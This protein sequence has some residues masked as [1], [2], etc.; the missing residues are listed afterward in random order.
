MKILVTNDDGI[1]AVGLAHLAEAMAEIGEVAVVAPDREMSA[2]GHSLTLHHP[3]RAHCLG[4]RRFAVDGTPTDCVNLGI[5]S[6][7]DFTPDLVVSGINRGGNLGDDVTYSGTVSAAME[8]TLMGIPAIAVS[9][10][11]MADGENYPSA[12][13]VAQEIARNLLRNGLP[14]DTFLNVNVP[15]LP[16]DRLGKTLV[17]IQGKR[18]YDGT[19]VDKVDPRGRNYYWIGTADLKFNDIEGSD[20]HA[21][22]RGHVSVTP[23]HLDLTNHSSIPKIA[24]WFSG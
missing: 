23:L 11:T 18:R 8:A 7:L 5:H 24:S 15:D 9:L 21:V 2:V 17:T 22:S 20:Y 6:L 3:L 1:N 12:A 14:V 4:E 16:Y 10:V 19:I 13:K